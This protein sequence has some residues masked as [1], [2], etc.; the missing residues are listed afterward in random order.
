MGNQV[1]LKTNDMLLRALQDA[2][3]KK[4]SQKEIMDQRVSFVFGSLDSSSNVT[5]ERV[6]KIIEEQDGLITA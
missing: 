1:E 6:R 3:S 4:P 5:R 2:V